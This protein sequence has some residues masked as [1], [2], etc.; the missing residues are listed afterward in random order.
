MNTRSINVTMSEYS[1]LKNWKFLESSCFISD[2]RFAFIAII[3]AASGI[4]LTNCCRDT[5]G[6]RVYDLN[7]DII[8]KDK[9]NKMLRVD[10]IKNVKKINGEDRLLACDCAN[11]EKE[12]DS[13]KI[14]SAEVIITDKNG[15]LWKN[16]DT[17][18]W[19]VI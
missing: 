9:N 1:S 18:R 2:K 4:T 17:I 5:E 3:S 16:D 10:T 14:V 11:W 19:D 6:I 15:S 8:W 12:Y 7:V 13:E